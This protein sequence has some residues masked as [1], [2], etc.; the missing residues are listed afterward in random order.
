MPAQLITFTEPATATQT[1]GDDRTLGTVEVEPPHDGIYDSLWRIADRT[2]GDGSRW[3]DIYALNRGR[4]Q[5]DGHALT[6][7]NLIRP[8]WIF[9]LPND[10]PDS[11]TYGPGH[12]KPISPP[13]E[14]PH[15]PQTS[16]PSTSSPSPSPDTSPPTSTPPPNG[17]PTPPSTPTELPSYRPHGQPGISLPTGAFVGIGLAALI[18][19]AL[20]TV[21][22]R[23]RVRY[24]PGSGERDDLTIAPVVRAL[25]RAYDDTTRSGDPDL[26]ERSDAASAEPRPALPEALRSTD[27]EPDATASPSTGGRVIG[28]K[29]GQSLAWDL[30][31]V[32]GLGL[33][34]PGAVDAIR[35]LLL[36]LLAESRHPTAVPIEILIPAS[37]ARMLIGEHVGH[38]G[39][40]RIVDDIDAALEAME[41]ELLTRTRTHTEPGTASHADN[42]A[43]GDLVLV[44]TPAP[45]ADRRLQ[46]LLDNGSTLG[47]AGILVGQWRPGVTARIRPDGNVTATSP[48]AA[49]SLTGAR[50]FTLPADDAQAL[51]D[52]LHEAEP[53]TP[54]PTPRPPG[55]TAP[56]NPASGN[57]SPGPEPAA[58]GPAPPRPRHCP[59]DG[60]AT[61]PPDIRQTPTAARDQR[62]G[63][64]NA[65]R[66][67]ASTATP[68]AA[69]LQ[70]ATTPP[71]PGSAPDEASTPPG[72]G[73]AFVPGTPPTTARSD[74]PRRVT[75]GRPAPTDT[76]PSLADGGDAP[77][78]Q[79]A[80][81]QPLK[82]AVLGRMR[83]THHRGDGGEHANLTDD[84]SPRQREV[85]AYLAL[86]RHGARRETLTAA[87]WPDAPR[88]RPSNAFHATVSQ[89]RRSLRAATHD[90]VRDITVHHDGHY[91]LDRDQVAVDLWELQDALEKS[92][93]DSDEP[94][95]RAALE[96]AVDLYA[97]DLADDLATEWIEVPRESL[98]RDV[99][100]A[101]SALVR[102]VRDTDPEQALTLLERARV[103]D[104]Y[105]EALYCDIARLQAELDQHDA[106]P[107]TLAL[108]TTTLAE[109][110]D[111]PS[112]DT[113]ALF[114]RLQRRPPRNRQAS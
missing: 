80:T 61:T 68:G 20:F 53:V 106:I 9:R 103:L 57:L 33:I 15:P 79:L 46:A 25:R 83:L 60:T 29:D 44:A 56:E 82:L 109:V 45:H 21:R 91:G 40:L 87:L 94:R 24:R 31:R 39:R 99:L 22:R 52:L 13:S 62:T 41:T 58:S 43:H 65:K 98:R 95:R 23:R 12:R 5:P 71:R 49:D 81:Q 108:L 66:P 16:V 96:H 32:H 76:A 51:L 69:D 110:D 63:P 112:P 18:T 74:A 90:A 1:Q 86:H 97:G 78:R 84:L 47:L 59:A 85:L 19:A 88:D 105:N 64:D 34:G 37:D 54:P 8:G 11:G 92:R 17:T 114:E 10:P 3:P 77:R 93:S 48:S 38:P 72:P 104:R 36:A 111:E 70:P 100:D 101:V 50:L 73:P 27:D 107:R 28:I 42:P 75:T 102:S 89:L 26:S 6:T 30:A 55:T 35:A 2:L 4:P 113:V 67:E 14:S 7:P